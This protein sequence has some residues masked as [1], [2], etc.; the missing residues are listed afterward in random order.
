M[1]TSISL[2]ELVAN[3]NVFVPKNNE[4][5]HKG[6]NV[7]LWPY[8]SINQVKYN[9]VLRYSIFASKLYDGNKKLKTAPILNPNFY[10]FSPKG[11]YINTDDLYFSK[12]IVPEHIDDI[13]KGE[14]SKFY[15]SKTGIMHFNNFDILYDAFIAEYPNVEFKEFI[16]FVYK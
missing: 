13:R 9:Q 4:Y 6:I 5:K 12:F 2:D 14:L 16:I 15:V 8:S 3:K 10:L 11:G 7:C 1:S